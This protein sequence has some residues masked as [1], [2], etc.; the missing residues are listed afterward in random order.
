MV[1]HTFEFFSLRLLKRTELVAL[2]QYGPATFF[3][4]VTMF[5]Q[6]RNLPIYKLQMAIL[7]C[8]RQKSKFQI[9]IRSTLLAFRES[10]VL[11]MRA[12]GSL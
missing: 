5:L 4:F 11:L 10:Q 9:R 1:V 8:E 6:Y 3:S 12:L 7:G 2:K